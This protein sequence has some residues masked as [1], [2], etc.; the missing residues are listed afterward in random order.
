TSQTGLTDIRPASADHPEIDVFGEKIN[1]RFVIGHFKPN[2][3]THG[4][5]WTEKRGF[6]DIGTLDGDVGSLVVG[7]NDRGV[8][9]GNSFS[10]GSS[11]AF[12]WSRSSG[13]V[14]LDTPAGWSSQANAMNGDFIVGSRCDPNLT[15]H[16]TLWKPSSH[17]HHQQGDDDDQD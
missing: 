17:S 16:A 9:A 6:V 14:P 12:V 5:V 2:N 10:G 11:R 15:C 1:G 4:F 7:V 3:S 13:I 8:V